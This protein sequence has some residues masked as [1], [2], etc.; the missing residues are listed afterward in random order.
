MERAT[1]LI[2]Q[3]NETIK[4]KQQKMP[5]IIFCKFVNK[6]GLNIEQVT[7]GIS[8]QITV[9]SSFLPTFVQVYTQASYIIS[10]QIHHKV[11]FW[12][13]MFTWSLPQYSVHMRIISGD[14]WGGK[15]IPPTN[16][17]SRQ[18]PQQMWPKKLIQHTLNKIDFSETRMSWSLWET[19]NC[20]EFTQGCTECNLRR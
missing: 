18:G 2:I 15:F 3:F 8:G 7:N 6:L 13:I 1:I 12:E 20:Y 16:Q 10:R 14:F 5:F 17:T 19:G 9:N 4:S 11:K